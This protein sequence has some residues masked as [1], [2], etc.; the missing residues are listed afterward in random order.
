MNRFL[1]K[2]LFENEV[3]YRDISIVESPNLVEKVEVSKSINQDIEKSVV[4]KVES[5][6][7]KPSIIL[8]HKVLVLINPIT[9]SEKE[10]LIKILKA[11]GVSIEQ[12]DLIVFNKSQDLDYQSVISQKIT[13]HF[14]S[15]G[16]GMSK[17]G[18][19]MLLAPYQVKKIEGISFLLADTLKDIEVSQNL[20]KSLWGALK[21]MFN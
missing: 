6:F 12:V 20:K 19:S 13:T 11:V 4:E 5:E 18:W 8:K 16:I 1:A 2:Y 21:E 7:P 15:F 3:L 17:L 10:L 14:I 9:D